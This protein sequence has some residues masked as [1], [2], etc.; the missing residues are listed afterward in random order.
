MTELPPIKWEP[1]KFIPIPDAKEMHGEMAWDEWDQA[2][3]ELD[4]KEKQ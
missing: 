3:R 4:E 1:I 2:V